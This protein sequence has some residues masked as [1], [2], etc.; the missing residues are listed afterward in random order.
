MQHV[1]C[2]MQHVTVALSEGEDS[3]HNTAEKEAKRDTAD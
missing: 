2:V 3:Q 1:T